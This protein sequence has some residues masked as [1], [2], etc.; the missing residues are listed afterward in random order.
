MTRHTHQ[1]A[2][3]QIAEAN[4]IRFAYRR[5]GNPTGVQS[6]F[7][8]D[9]VFRGLCDA[10][11]HCACAWHRSVA[12]R[13]ARCRQLRRTRDSRRLRTDGGAFRKVRHMARRAG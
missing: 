6:P 2:P 13:L 8:I 11:G 1:S 12:N 5:F 10:G 9:V 3:T 7:T 4:G